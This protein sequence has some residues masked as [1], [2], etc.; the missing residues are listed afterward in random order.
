MIP[1]VGAER[2]ADGVELLQQHFQHAALV[3]APGTKL[4]MRTSMKLDSPA[5]LTR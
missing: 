3:G 2:L 1:I 5:G 4:T